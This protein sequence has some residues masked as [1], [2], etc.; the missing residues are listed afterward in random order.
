ML[1][2]LSIRAIVLIE[3]LDLRDDPRF[4]TPRLRADQRPA[5]MEELARWAK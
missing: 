5:L 2:S 4:A 1:A 3:R